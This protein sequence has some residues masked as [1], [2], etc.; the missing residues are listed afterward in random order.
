MKKILIVGAAIAAFLTMGAQSAYAYCLDFAPSG[1]CDLVQVNVSSGIVYGVWDSN[2]DAI[3]DTSVIGTAGLG[4]GD[5]AG[6]PWKDG[7]TVFLWDVNVSAST[8]DLWQ[9]D[10]VN[11]IQFQS[12]IP[13]ILTSGACSFVA[14]EGGTGASAR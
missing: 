14:S 12:N 7:V 11:L 3:A 13:F 8:A 10:G 5:V 6:D 1:F 9:N 2:C 4:T